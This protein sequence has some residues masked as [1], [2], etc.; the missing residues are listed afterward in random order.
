ME[1]YLPV[2]AFQRLPMAEDEIQ[3]ASHTLRDPVQPDPGLPL[4]P[5]LYLT[6]IR[7]AT[8]AF[9]SALSTP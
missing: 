3:N 5:H 9:F 1:E 6:L 4:W 8:L 2:K 7:V